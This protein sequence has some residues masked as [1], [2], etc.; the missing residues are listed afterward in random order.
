MY[1][2]MPYGLASMP[3][4]RSWRCAYAALAEGEHD[5]ITNFRLID[6][7]IFEIPYVLDEDDDDISRLIDL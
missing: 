5:V 3:Y 6:F 2:Y 7:Q 1:M 4:H